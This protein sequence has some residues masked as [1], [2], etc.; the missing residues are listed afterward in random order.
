MYLWK[1]KFNTHYCFYFLFRKN[2]VLNISRKQNSRVVCITTLPCLNVGDLN[3]IFRQ[4]ETFIRHRFCISLTYKRPTFRDS[5]KFH[6]STPVIKSS[7]GIIS[8]RRVAF[9]CLLTC[10]IKFFVSYHKRSLCRVINV[11]CVAS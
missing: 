3:S 6:H 10:R 9:I 8:H 1:F 11:L 2:M 4:I 5:Y 7:F